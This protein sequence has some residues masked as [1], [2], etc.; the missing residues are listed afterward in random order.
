ME[1]DHMNDEVKQK[2]TFV[3]KVLDNVHKV[4]IG[5]KDLVERLLIGILANGHLLVESVPGLAKTLS[6]KTLSDSIQTKFQRIQFTPDLLPADIIGTL[7]YN[8]KESV[9]T[10]KKGPIFSNII[11]ADEINRAPAK[12]QSALLEAM[13]ERQVTIGDQTFKMEEPFLVMATQN[14][15]EQEGTYPLPEAQLDRFL[16]KVNI[17]Y[18]SST[19]EV[20][21]IT[22]MTGLSGQPSVAPVVNPTDIVEARKLV[23]EIHIDETLKKYIVDIVFSTRYPE[24][25]G[26]KQFNNM[27]DLGASP[28]ASLSLISA[29]KAYAFIQGRGFV[30]P[31]DIK[32][33]SL[34]VLRHRIIPSYEAEA[35]EI[36]AET[37][38]KKIFDT[39]PIP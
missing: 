1:K 11:L 33:I 8:P 15:V 3:N 9:F 27:I 4:I 5:Q 12:V 23:N 34:D 20:D 31:D 30:I 35:E 39:V 28:R 32:Q 36:T 25:Y 6:I 38:I 17:S 24:K 21:M 2:S 10:I 37:I 19:E 13:Q 7:I 22:R 26:L 29:A 16:M 14:P 18:L